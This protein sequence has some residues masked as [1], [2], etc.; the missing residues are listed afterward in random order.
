MGLVVGSLI[1]LIIG[2]IVG[3]LLRGGRLSVSVTDAR[4]P[5]RAA[6][7]LVGGGDASIA[8]Q[9]AP[10][11]DNNNHLPLLPAARTG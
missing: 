7:T 2:S 6:Y 3:H 10:H 11:A 8:I 4:L 5:V 1:G 9:C